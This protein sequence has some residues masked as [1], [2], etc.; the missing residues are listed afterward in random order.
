MV[1]LLT[2]AFPSLREHRLGGPSD[3]EAAAAATAAVPRPAILGR[4]SCA[5]AEKEVTPVR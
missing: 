4:L 1:I 3:L 2:E 5:A